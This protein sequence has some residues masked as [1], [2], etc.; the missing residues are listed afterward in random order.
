MDNKET[1]WESGYKKGVVIKTI[2][3]GGAM[4][5]MYDTR[6]IRHREGA[7]ASR[8][9]Q[10]EVNNSRREC[11]TGKVHA[12]SGRRYL[13]PAGGYLRRDGDADGRCAY[14]IQGAYM[15]LIRCAWG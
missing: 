12:A 10:P 5:C 9:L 13:R 11:G 8:D 4:V 14:L 2:C 7:Y 3:M 6:E 1:V 15:V